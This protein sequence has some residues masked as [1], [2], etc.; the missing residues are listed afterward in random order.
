MT[1][2]QSETAPGAEEEFVPQPV[3]ADSVG[4]LQD[5]EATEAASGTETVA[6]GDDDEDE[7]D[8]E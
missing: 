4:D 7:G 1:E 8:E 2:S 3:D 6:A 5:E